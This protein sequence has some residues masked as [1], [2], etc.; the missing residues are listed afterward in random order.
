MPQLGQ[1]K[2][3]YRA[4]EVPEIEFNF[5]GV[6]ALFRA[7][8]AAYGD[9]QARDLIGAVAAGL[10]HSHTNTSL[11]PLLRP[12]KQLMATLDP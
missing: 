1:W 6:G 3:S 12:T 7:T 2:E 4:H 10:H 8:L 11:E 9:S 5:L